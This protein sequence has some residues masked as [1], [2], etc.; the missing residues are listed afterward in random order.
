[1][2]AKCPSVNAAAVEQDDFWSDV[3]H[4][5][6]ND[7]PHRVGW[8]IAGI[9]A[10]VTLL[11]SLC[12]VLGHGLHYH[13]PAQQRQII[14]IV[15]FAPVF[16]IISFFSYRFF[17]SYTYYSYAEVVWEAIAIASF[18]MLCLAYIA[19]GDVAQRAAFAEKEKSKLPMPFCCWR[20]RP[21]K[22]YFLFMV[23]FSVTQYCVIRPLLSI[24]AIVLQSQ[25]LLCDESLSYK[26]GHVYILAIDFASITV[27]L[28][29]LLVLYGLIKDDLKGRRPLAKFLTI[30]LAVF[31]VFYQSFVFS[32]LQ[33]HGVIK[34]TK[35]WSATNVADGLD[36]LCITLE[37][38]LVAAFQMWAFH[39][40][41]Y[42]KYGK[43][44]RFAWHKEHAM[45]GDS[46]EIRADNGKA[47]KA[48]RPP[49][50]Y[51]NPLWA[52]I[53]S[54]WLG[55]LFYELFRSLRFAFDRMC[56]K[57]YT[58][59]DYRLSVGGPN[60]HYQFGSVGAISQDHLQ[61]DG[62]APGANLQRL[63]STRTGEEKLSDA[64]GV[65]ETAGMD[66]Q[67]VFLSAA[68]SRDNEMRG[69]ASGAT[70]SLGNGGRTSPRSEATALTEG[71]DGRGG[72][73][74]ALS[75][76]L[77][78]ASYSNRGQENHGYPLHAQPSQRSNATAAGSRTR[79]VD[80]QGWYPSGYA[81]NEAPNRQQPPPLPR[82]Y[83][84]QQ[85]QQQQQQYYQQQQ[86]PEMYA[87]HQPSQSSGFYSMPAARSQASLHSSVPAS[88]SQASLHSHH[89][90]QAHASSQPPQP[91]PPMPMPYHL[92]QP[93]QVAQVPQ[94]GERYPRPYVAPSAAAGSSSSQRAVYPPQHQTESQQRSQY[95][96]PPQPPSW[97]SLS[98]QPPPRPSRDLSE[99]SPLQGYQ[100]YQGY[101]G[102]GPNYAGASEPLQGPTMAGPRIRQPYGAQ[103]PTV[104]DDDDY[105]YDNGGGSGAGLGAASGAPNGTTAERPLSWEP[106][107][108]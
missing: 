14:R 36:A 55:D 34:G 101:A 2:V 66:F 108:M 63:A 18:L 89:S 19:E 3:I 69:L 12:T 73:T 45:K 100:G 5:T 9:A 87:H 93:P 8:S 81:Y 27:A 52:L 39:W 105:Q 56:G 38:V 17:R 24:A 20:Y 88:R 1:M 70:S 58:K 11:I 41:E 86:Q 30:K 16:A 98:Q 49:R 84:Q 40:G 46:G 57:E 65:Q 10:A 42:R 29:G 21:S 103:P 72:S 44:Q 94:P 33:D 15:L 26:Y 64:A 76:P 99:P 59:T 50:L 68:A 47:K 6:W 92:Q 48:D 79:L 51:T 4:G 67:Q 54:L 95:S 82:A 60:I 75:A 43:E 74:D 102:G 7:D 96:Q 78:E 85:Q 53:H 91:P 13:K 25:E 77:V 32:L 83:Q 31:F 61:N 23:K 37:M 104:Y 97:Q 106:Q 22:A 35:Y 80:E 62:S 71:L 28:Y 107:A 90:S